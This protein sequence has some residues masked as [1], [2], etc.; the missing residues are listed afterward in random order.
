MTSSL[1][2][3]FEWCYHCSNLS[4]FHENQPSPGRG[5][6]CRLDF[7]FWIA[8][9][10]DHG[11]T[12]LLCRW[13]RDWERTGLW[14]IQCLCPELIMPVACKGGKVVCAVRLNMSWCSFAPVGW[15][16]RARRAG[17]RAAGTD[18]ELA[19]SRCQYVWTQRNDGR[20]KEGELEVEALYLILFLSNYVWSYLPLSLQSKEAQGDSHMIRR[21]LVGRGC[22]AVIG[23]HAV[24][25]PQETP[26]CRVSVLPCILSMVLTVFS[27]SF[28]AFNKKQTNKKH[29]KRPL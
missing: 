14:E 25:W 3:K 23:K 22:L 15:R 5:C 19:A 11:W 1:P 21:S 4:H 16:A 18:W 24:S 12:S 10:L 6:C 17:K 20:K 29:F 28:M 26:F 7:L 9:T 27:F 13:K 8:L 2:A